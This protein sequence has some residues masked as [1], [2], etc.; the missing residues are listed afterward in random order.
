MR[1]SFS[2]V[3][4]VAAAPNLL[5]LLAAGVHIVAVVPLLAYHR[6]L[7]SLLLLASLLLEGVLCCRP[8]SGQ[9]QIFY[10]DVTV[11]S[12]SRLFSLHVDG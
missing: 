5:L 7:V 3:N 1:A 4:G 8:C 6:L 9:C 10:D 2:A 12:P 11:H